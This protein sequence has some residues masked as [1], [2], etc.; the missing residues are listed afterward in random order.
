MQCIVK[1]SRIESQW[2]YMARVSVLQTIPTLTACI[3]TIY[4]GKGGNCIHCNK[5]NEQPNCIEHYEIMMEQKHI[6][7]QGNDEGRMQWCI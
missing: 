2:Y 1:Q 3:A 7:I 6:H 4:K 5:D